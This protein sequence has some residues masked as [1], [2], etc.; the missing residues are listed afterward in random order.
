MIPQ[1]YKDIYRILIIENKQEI[2]KGVF[3]A[4]S[5]SDGTLASRNMH[6]KIKFV[7]NAKFTFFIGRNFFK[8]DR[9][10]I[11]GRCNLL[12]PTAKSGLV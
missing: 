12:M 11:Q 10:L 4:A 1:G 6:S 8:M 3:T 7:V 9:T 2:G 5:Y